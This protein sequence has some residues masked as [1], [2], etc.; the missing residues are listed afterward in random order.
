MSQP[1][2]QTA[3]RAASRATSKASQ[4]LPANKATLLGGHCAGGASTGGTAATCG[5]DRDGAEGEP[6]SRQRW[7]AA[8][9][10]WQAEQCWRAWEE[11][12]GA[13]HVPSSER[14]EYEGE[15]RGCWRA[16]EEREGAE[17][18]PSCERSE[19]EGE[20]RGC[21]CG[22][23]ACKPARTPSAS[24]CSLCWDLHVGSSAGEARAREERSAA[25]PQAL[26]LCLQHIYTWH[27]R[28]KAPG[29]EVLLLVPGAHGR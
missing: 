8:A 20:A 1:V 3:G 27:S 16:S 26:S 5:H 2:H 21:S 15:A 19:C 6:R 9:P 14:S 23:Q 17:H 4:R 18:V 25:E 13:E 11:R 24:L 28:T 12:E 7:D 10:L 22:S 29:L